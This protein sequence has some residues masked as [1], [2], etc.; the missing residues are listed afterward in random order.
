MGLRQELQAHLEAEMVDT[1]VVVASE[2]TVYEAGVD[3]VA[4][5]AVV[6]N[7]G[8]PYE[9]VVTMKQSAIQTNLELF[10]VAPRAEPA[11]AFTYLED[12]RLAVT[13]ALQTMVPAFRWVNHGGFGGTEVAGVVYATSMLEIITVKRERTT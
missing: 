6:I 3:I 10:L 4:V 1:G 13:N 7:P 11:A 9:S 2:V 8:D 12:L 5:P